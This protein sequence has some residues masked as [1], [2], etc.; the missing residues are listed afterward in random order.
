M[1]DYLDDEYDDEYE[2][3]EGYDD[4]EDE[5]DDEYTD[6]DLD[7]FENREKQS[8]RN[9][10][11]GRL[12]GYIKVDHLPQKPSAIDSLARKRAS[13][14]IQNNSPIDKLPNGYTRQDYLDAGWS[15]TD[16]ELWGLDQ[17]AAPDPDSAA[18]VIPDMLDGDL[19][20]N[21]E[22]PFN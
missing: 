10:P 15:E 16:I 7:E 4:F 19:V 14:P 17:P 11:N 3:D 21:F 6:E 20:G 8:K 22:Y 13:E 2:D 9:S 1:S 12:S 18:F 5:R